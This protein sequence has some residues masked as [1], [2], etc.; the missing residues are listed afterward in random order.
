MPTV[1][2]DKHDLRM[3]IIVVGGAS[4]LFVNALTL[5]DG[6]L[7]LHETQGWKPRFVFDA[8]PV[9]PWAGDGASGASLQKLVP[10]ID[11][12]VLTDALKEGTHYSSTAV[13]RLSRAL[14]PV[15]IAVPTAIFGGPALAEEWTT[16]S[17]V[18]PVYVGEP[19]EQNAM[20]A[21]K[22]L[23]KVLLRSQMKSTPPPPPA[24]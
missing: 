22:G 6:E 20:N 12:L 13:E 3:E 19:T 1:D 21:V 18:T 17:G 10:Y 14:K 4:E 15:K 11:G 7:K 9:D 24:R 16:L 8:F 5:T 2:Y 23:A